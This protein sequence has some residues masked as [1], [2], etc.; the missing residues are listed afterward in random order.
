MGKRANGLQTHTRDELIIL[1]TMLGCDIGGDADA[2]GK[3]MS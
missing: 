2:D 1:E 3:A